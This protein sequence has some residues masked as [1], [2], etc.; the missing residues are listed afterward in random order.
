MPNE[1]RQMDLKTGRV[2]RKALFDEEEKKDDDDDDDAVSDE[3]DEQE[4]EAMSEGG[5]DGDDEDDAEEES[6]E[7]L[8][9]AKMAPG[10]AKRLRTEVAKEETV[11]E[12]P[13]FA[14]SDDDLE[15]SSE[16]G[17]AASEEDDDDDDDERTYGNDSSDSEF[18]AGSKGILE[19]EQN[20]VVNEDKETKSQLLVR[21][22]KKKS[23]LTTDS[24]NCT[25]EEASESEVESLSEGDD[26]EK[27]HDELEAEVSDRKGFQ[28]PQPKKADRTRPAEPESIEAEDDDVEDL[29][30]EEEEY[31]EKTDFSA[32]TAGRL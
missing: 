24:G 12:L 18:E 30:R 31:E 7:E 21:S 19:S 23:L 14:D 2:R 13:A 29:L 22:L 17:K 15:M 27:S 25:A 32:D 20:E 8:L 1:E 26:E 28:H 5:S 3:E 10:S 11:S 6:D 16:E 4:E 9:E